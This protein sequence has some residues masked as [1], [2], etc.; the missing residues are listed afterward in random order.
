MPKSMPSYV[1]LCQY[2]AAIVAL[3]QF[4]AMPTARIDYGGPD[5]P[6]DGRYIIYFHMFKQMMSI[7]FVMTITRPK[8]APVLSRSYA[9]AFLLAIATAPFTGYYRGGVDTYPFLP[10]FSDR[11]LYA[12]GSFMHCFVHDR[13]GVM[14]AADGS[15]L[16]LPSSLGVGAL[17]AYMFHPVTIVILA[18]LAVNWHP[19]LTALVILSIF[20][21]VA[22][23]I[24]MAS[25]RKKGGD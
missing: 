25:G 23:G 12:G 10:F 17:L 6:L 21:L 3:L 18:P 1:R 19:G 20:T 14:F 22:Q 24:N 13:L 5:P 11:L 16:P 7:G 4:I 9:L 15:S 8:T 2:A